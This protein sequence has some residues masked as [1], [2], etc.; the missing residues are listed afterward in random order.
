MANHE[1]KKWVLNLNQHWGDNNVTCVSKNVDKCI[2][3]YD[4]DTKH[5]GGIIYCFIIN[6]KVN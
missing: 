4:F 5:L 6:I 2:A 3:A 1:K